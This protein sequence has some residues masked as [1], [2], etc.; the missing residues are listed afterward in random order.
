M[1]QMND[2]T[3]RDLIAMFALNGI[4]A[5]RLAP[6]RPH[7]S[8]H[9]MAPDLVSREETCQIAYEYADAMLAAHS[10]SPAVPPESP[11]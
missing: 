11:T 3:P 1:D 8:G 4:L 7:P 2:M 5:G 10:P 9:P 6:K